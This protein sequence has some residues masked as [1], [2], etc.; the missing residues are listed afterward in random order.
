MGE[1]LMLAGAVVLGWALKT[2]QRRTAEDSAEYEMELLR[3]AT[4][5]QVA[6]ITQ[7]ENEISR[8]PGNCCCVDG[9]CGD[10]DKCKRSSL[11]TSLKRIRDE[12]KKPKRR[13]FENI[14]K[15]VDDALKEE[16]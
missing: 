10:C 13:R 7:L 6:H 4:V 14:Q 1:F 11:G 9:K 5:A 16:S 2:L 3:V 8:L 12:V 15:F